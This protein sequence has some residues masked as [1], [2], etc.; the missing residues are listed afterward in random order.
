[1]DDTTFLQNCFLLLPDG[2]LQNIHYR[3]RIFSFQPATS[4]S[5][6]R[7][8]LKWKPEFAESGEYA[9]IVQASDATGNNAGVHM[10]TKCRFRLYWKPYSMCWLSKPVFNRNPGCLY[11]DR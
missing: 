3:G 2:N 9:L 11:P 8:L 7:A 6:N 10:I 1:M 4:A 5:D